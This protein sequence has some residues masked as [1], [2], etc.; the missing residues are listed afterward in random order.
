MAIA[1]AEVPEAER[2]ALMRDIA[3]RV[4]G[5]FGEPVEAPMATYMGIARL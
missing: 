5:R 2:A 1:L 3:D 4:R